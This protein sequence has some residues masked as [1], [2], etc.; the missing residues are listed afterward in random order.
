MNEGKTQNNGREWWRQVE[1][2][3]DHLVGVTRGRNVRGGE[4]G[5]AGRIEWAKSRVR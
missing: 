5:K 2:G 4:S 3:G 1:K